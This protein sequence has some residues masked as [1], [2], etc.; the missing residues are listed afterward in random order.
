MTSVI[1]FYDTSDTSV[2]DTFDITLYDT[3]DTSGSDTSDITLVWIRYGT[4][5]YTL[6][7]RCQQT[8]N[9]LNL[10]F[11]RH[12]C[13]KSLKSVV[14]NHSTTSTDLT[15]VLNNRISNW[16]KFMQLC[17]VTN[18]VNYWWYWK[19]NHTWVYAVTL[20][21]QLLTRQAIKA[22]QIK[23]RA[24]RINNTSIPRTG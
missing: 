22:N 2:S 11:Y 16:P 19:L 1:L 8:S 23:S 12:C 20:P 15:I 24:N 14:R 4:T 3:S 9:D 10:H 21:C 13:Q 7:T 6:K 17:L 18:S 5:F